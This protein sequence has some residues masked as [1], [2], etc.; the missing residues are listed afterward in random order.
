MRP[1]QLA[2]YIAPSAPATR[3]PASGGEPFLRPEIGFTPDWYHAKLGINFDRRWHSDVTY[4]GQVIQKMSEELKNR[5]PGI[6]IGQI[7]QEQE[8]P[9]L[10]TGTFGCTAV[11]AIFGVPIV[12]VEDGWP[13][14][15]PEYLSVSQVERL[16]VPDLGDN[17]FFS[18]LMIQLDRIA[19]HQGQ[20]VGFINW[21]GI[22]NNAQRLR[23]PDI[24]TDM[25]DKPDLCHHLFGCIC[26]TMIGGM[27]GLQE[28][29]RSTG[30]DYQFATISNCCVNMI[31]PDHYAQFILP[32]DTQI[33]ES[34]DVIG[35]HNCAWNA[36]PYMEYYADIPN[37]GY[38]DMGLRSN[39]AQAREL[40]P[41][42]RRALMYTPMDLESKS[43]GDIHDDIMKIVAC[44]APCDIVVADID[45]DVPDRKIIEFVKLC[46]RYNE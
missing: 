28:R 4:R 12:Y 25:I 30:V 33:A 24:F 5:F 37:L 8:T 27:L 26:R 13:T 7:S 11:A 35:I 17:T 34:F 39:L 9:D 42:A 36:D 41:N 21:Q 1:R 44:Y 23:G 3:R 2:S 14:T 18:N 20:I 31:S 22:L 40:M 43:I 10:L 32:Y 45:K 46:Q 16:D 29:Q 15:A 38:I 19:E 6:S